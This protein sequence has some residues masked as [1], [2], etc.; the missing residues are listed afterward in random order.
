MI[1]SDEYVSEMYLI[2]SGRFV[3]AK[4]VLQH[5]E[6]MNIVNDIDEIEPNVIIEAKG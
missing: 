4:K 6:N 2:Q 1:E 3:I 5:N